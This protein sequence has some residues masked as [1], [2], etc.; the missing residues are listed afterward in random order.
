MHRAGAATPVQSLPAACLLAASSMLPAFS[1]ATLQY[2]SLTS[3]LCATAIAATYNTSREESACIADASSVA[4]ASRSIVH[5]HELCFR[6]S[7][8]WVR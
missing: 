1:R 5:F 3:V 6:L 8:T 7:E 2:I 4:F